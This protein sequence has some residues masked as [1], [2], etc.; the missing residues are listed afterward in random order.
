VGVSLSAEFGYQKKEYSTD[1]WNV[2]IRPIVDKQFGNLYISFN[3]T[4]G[5]GLKGVSND[6]TTGF[7]PNIKT[8]YTFNKVALGFEYY[9]DL[10]QLNQMPE[11]NQQ[12]HALFFV[13]DLFVDPMWEF[14]FG[15]GFGLTNATDGF[16]FKLIVG[17]R[18]NWKH[19]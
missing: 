5:I 2:E 15:P 9:G 1:T 11:I 6:H 4:F 3:P 13:A 8:S 10:G 19:H 12:G 17:R 16:V 14:N 7:E 18:I